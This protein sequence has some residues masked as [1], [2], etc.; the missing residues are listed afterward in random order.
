MRLSGNIEN[1]FDDVL[2]FVSENDYFWVNP[3]FFFHQKRI[4]H[5]PHKVHMK[6]KYESFF[7]LRNF[8]DIFEALQNKDRGWFWPVKTKCLELSFDTLLIKKE[9]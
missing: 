5:L 7:F 9:L 2:W 3:P 1:D 6:S 4:E 8:Y